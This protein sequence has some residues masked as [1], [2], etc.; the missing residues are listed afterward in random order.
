MEAPENFNILSNSQMLTLHILFGSI[1][2]AVCGVV[3]G[4]NANNFGGD[5]TVEQSV[6]LSRIEFSVLYLLHHTA[7]CKFLLYLSERGLWC[8]CSKSVKL[9]S[10]NSKNH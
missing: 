1:A 2:T 3:V 9:Q 5:S 8:L 7:S 4:N 10:E 6:N